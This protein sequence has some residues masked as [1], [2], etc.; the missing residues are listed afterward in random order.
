MNL[1][2][3][4]P[5]MVKK[6][7]MVPGK[8]KKRSEK[9]AKK[10]KNAREMAYRPLKLVQHRSKKY[11]GTVPESSKKSLMGRRADIN[12][13]PSVKTSG[14]SFFPERTLLVGRNL[15]VEDCFLVHRNLRRNHRS[16]G[17]I[18]NFPAITPTTVLR[19][20]QRS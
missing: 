15:I 11:L 1:V 7:K 8:S 19:H 2:H 17:C 16:C 3:K 20:Q 9:W 5:K 18:S 10:P 13:R 14:R 6:S 12:F 4:V